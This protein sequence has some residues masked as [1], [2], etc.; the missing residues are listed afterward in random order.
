M[1]HPLDDFSSVQIER[2]LRSQTPEQLKRY[3]QRAERREEQLLPAS[4]LRR[5]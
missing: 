4:F 3:Q 2:M 5:S 1:A